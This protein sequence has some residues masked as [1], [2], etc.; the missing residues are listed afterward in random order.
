MRRVVLI[1]LLV[2]LAGLSWASTYTVTSVADSDTG[3]LRAAITQANSHAGAD[4]IAFDPSLSGHRIKPLSV[5][6]P[7]TDNGTTI[8]GDLLGDGV[9]KIILDG[10]ALSSGSGLRVHGADCVIAGL[11]VY[12][13][14]LCAI[15]LG[16]AS[17]CTIRSCHLNVNLAGSAAVPTAS[18]DFDG[19]VAYDANHCVIGGAT[20]K[21][22]NVI[23]SGVAATGTGHGGVFIVTGDYN[24]ISGNYFGIKRDGSGVLGTGCI[25]IVLGWG[26]ATSCSHN[27]VG[28]A[29]AGQR[30]LFGGVADGV[31]IAGPGASANVV[32]GNL[33]GLAPDGKTDL[34]ISNEGV[35]IQNS[36]GNVVGGTTPGARNVFAGG[37]TGVMCAAGASDNKIQGNYFGTNA[38]GTAG[39]ALAVGVEIAYQAGPQT[40]GGNTDAAGNFLVP[41]ADAFGMGIAI[42]GTTAKGCTISHNTFGIL[43]SGKAAPG[44]ASGVMLCSGAT[45]TVTENTFAHASGSAV[46]AAGSGARATVFRNIFRGCHMGVHLTD[47]G[48]AMLGKLGG[49]TPHGGSNTFELTNQW[50]IY[51]CTTA[52]NVKAEGNCFG[53]TSQAAI[54]AKI[55]DWD[56]DH[57]LGQ[58]DYDPLKGGEHPSGLAGPLTLTGAAAVPCARGAEIAFS[59]SGPASVSLE[60]LNL[61]GRVIAAPARDVRVGGGT[62]RLGWNGLSTGGTR[63]PSGSY[64]VSVTARAADGQQATTLCALTLR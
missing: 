40:I 39:R 60:V 8:N 13:F 28:G 25:G 48:G 31:C 23:A 54:D 20:A 22:R 21:D 10:S 37:S 4:T 5:L 16:G 44:P 15:E 6:P 12:H 50:F 35:T 47:G 56:N 24:E 52:T 17:T 41:A 26:D 3:T 2:H 42:S 9:P 11:V 61:A 62:N 46:H 27:V 33:F 34:P 57:A 29:A 63:A 64:L 32:S 43:P 49:P 38:A 30:N 55:W 14:P 58:V 59:L 45:A 36:Q 7:L 51:L 19:I 53:T 18:G 1:A